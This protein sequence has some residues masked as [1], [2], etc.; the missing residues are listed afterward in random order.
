MRTDW[1][2]PDQSVKREDWLLVVSAL[3]PYKRTDLVVQA[4]TKASL[5]LKI[6]GDG[7]QRAALAA[8]AG[9]TV[10]MLGRVDDEALR[11]LYR[12]ANSLVFPQVEDFGIIPVEAQATGCPII[13]FAGGGALETVTSQTGVFFVQHSAESL[14]EAITALDHAAIDPVA[15]RVNA[16]R[17]NE[18][19]FDEAIREAV[20]EL[21]S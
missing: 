17:F 6:A 2:T 19:V 8:M 3:E 18:Q 13:A 16:E 14:I 11:D 21:L 10:E 4:A 15:C 9:P 12:R 1:F 7:S 20:N 5:K